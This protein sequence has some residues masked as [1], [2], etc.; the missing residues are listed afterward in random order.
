[1]I[2]LT[3]DLTAAVIPADFTGAGLLAL[4]L[5]LLQGK[6]HD[7]LEFE[8]G[9]WT[10]AKRQLKKETH[11]KCAYCEAPTSRVA[12]G[13][14]EHFRPKK[15]YW[16]L[17]YFYGNY[18]YSCQICNQ[19]YKRDVFPIAGPMLNLDPA[20]PDPFPPLAPAAQLET[21]ARSL[22]P[23]PLDDAAGYPIARFLRALRREK[24][25]LIDPYSLDPEPFF[26]WV[27]DA[28]NGEVA[29]A[30]RNNRAA[31]KRTFEAVEQYLG[32]NREELRRA[33]WKTYEYL[34]TFQLG[35]QAGIPAT[36]RERS[37]Q[38]VRDMMADDAEFAGMVRYFVNV[39]WQ[40]DLT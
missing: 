18:L 29:I 37:K 22:C 5:R 36:L 40:L 17:A 6:I 7:N 9:Y 11:G 32:L 35:M 33:R 13:D 34:Y 16:W 21:V 2:R 1:M 3:R 12:H 39:E 38:M 28:T 30:P 10:K 15:T 14:V 27:V 31:V 25:A 24:P 19:T 4:K 8:S 26:K 23:D 20:L